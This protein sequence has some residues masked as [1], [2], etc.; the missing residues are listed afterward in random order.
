MPPRAH[1]TRVR[2]GRGA[3]DSRI[4]SR[5][6][7]AICGVSIGT[8][9]RALNNR[10]EISAR[11]RERILAAA[12]RLGYRPHLLA[13]GLVTG[14][15]MSI[16]VVMPNLRNPFFSELV[17]VIH[18]KARKAG[19]RLYLMLS[20]FNR[21]EEIESMNRLRGLHV[22]GIILC[23]VNRGRAFEEF[24]A[25]LATPVVTVA[26]RI[27][28]KWP[29]VGIDDRGAVRDA[30]RHVVSRGYRRIVFVTQKRIEAGSVSLH[31]DLQRIHGYRD[32]LREAGRRYTPIVVTD[33]DM[34]RMAGEG[35]LKDGPRTCVMCS[36]DAVALEVLNELKRR[37]L[38][39][40]EAVGLMG[41]D[42]LEELK[43]ITPKLST[44][45]SPIGRIGEEAFDR[46]LA[47][48]RGAPAGSIAL[49]HAILEGET[50]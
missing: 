14:T 49:D 33:E 8:V 47:A 22:D 5:R 27:S 26:S 21:Q 35:F 19:Y 1:R 29:W 46:L 30:V 44:V 40:P 32:A 43:Y 18:T 38:R 37:R 20:E 48:I 45:A 39:I 13:R 7:A 3:A 10:P 25:G 34:I 24:M 17:E 28:R 23:P 15:T 6:I 50:T 36:C 31:I 2:G 4:T 41:F 16:G 12:R 9:D 11:T 42:N